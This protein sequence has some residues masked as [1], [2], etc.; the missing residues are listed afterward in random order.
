[1]LS[2]GRQLVREVVPVGCHHGVADLVESTLGVEGGADQA[3][4][5]HSRPDAQRSSTLTTPRSQASVNS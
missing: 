1:V 3:E 4:H 2:A 5:R